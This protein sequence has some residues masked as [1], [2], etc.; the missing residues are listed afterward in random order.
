MNRHLQRHG[1]RIFGR[2][3]RDL[4][5]MSDELVRAV[6]PG[7]AQGKFATG[8]ARN[9]ER[10][11]ARDAQVFTQNADRI[12]ANHIAGA[13]DRKCGNGYAACQRLEL[14]NAERVGQAWKDEHVGCC[15]MRGKNPVVELAEKFGG[16]EAAFEIGLLRAGADD[17]LGAGQIERKKSRQILLDRHSADGHENW[18]REIQ[19]DGAIWTK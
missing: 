9:P 4:A 1:R 3:H 5:G 6:F 18:P 7:I 19:V 10:L 12:I 8:L 15:Q 16:R 13:S 11:H 14:H 17:D 2:G